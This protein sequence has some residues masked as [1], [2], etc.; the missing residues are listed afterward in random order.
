MDSAKVLKSHKRYESKKSRRFS[1]I[2]GIRWFK[3]Q[4]KTPEVDDT[5][6][7][8]SINSNSCSDNNTKSTIENERTEERVDNDVENVVPVEDHGDNIM[9]MEINPEIENNELIDRVALISG[10]LEAIV[11]VF[12]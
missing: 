11:L 12:F 1:N 8:D 3:V 9:D 4:A 6:Y 2:A 10:M 7:S 5:I